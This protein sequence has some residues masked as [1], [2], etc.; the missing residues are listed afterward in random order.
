VIQRELLKTILVEK[1][2]KLTLVIGSK[3]KLILS[4]GCGGTTVI[5][6]FASPCS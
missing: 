4:G 3:K 1:Q 5:E 2:E 6:T